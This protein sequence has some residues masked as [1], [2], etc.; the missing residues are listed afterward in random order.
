MINFIKI[1]LIGYL[2]PGILAGMAIAI[3]ALCNLN[4]EKYVGAILFIFGLATVVS[5]N[6]KLYTGAVGFVKGFLGWLS[7]IPTIIYNIIGA[8]AIT[9]IGFYMTNDLSVAADRI[10]EARLNAPLINTFLLSII[11]GFIM[12]VSV[13]QGRQKNWLPLITGIPLFVISCFPH[14]IADITYY[15]SSNHDIKECLTPWV[16][17]IFGNAVG[18]NIPTISRFVKID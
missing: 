9:Y 18:G 8:V 13:S 7:L 2:I 16:V 10:V 3:A 15:V 14:C 12:S 5:M 4:S 11:C 1:Y 17:S 6:W